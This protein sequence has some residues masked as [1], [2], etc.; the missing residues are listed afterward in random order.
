MTPT[1]FCCDCDSPGLDAITHGQRSG[2]SCFSGDFEPATDR[3]VVLA[4]I[5]QAAKEHGMVLSANHPRPFIPATV[6]PTNIG[7][8]YTALIR[9]GVLEP[10]DRD[11]RS[12]D[13]KSGNGGKK[14]PLY[15]FHPERVA[16]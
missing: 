11:D 10:L 13:G 15:R 4:A 14:I 3:A 1:V 2:H 9:E 16:A 12:T 5:R 6:V 7:K 8:T